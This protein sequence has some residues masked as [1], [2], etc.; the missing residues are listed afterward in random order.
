MTRPPFHADQVGSLLRPPELRDA[1]ASKVS[2]EKLKEVEDRC[3]ARGSPR[4]PRLPLRAGP[5][6]PPPRRRR[7]F[8]L[9]RQKGGGNLPEKGPPPKVFPPP[10]SQCDQLCPPGNPRRSRGDH[11][12]LP[13]QFPQHLV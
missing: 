4:R 9:V 2:P 5:P 11:A 8:L 12:H 3:I 13:W 10:L 1:R 7:L 6:P